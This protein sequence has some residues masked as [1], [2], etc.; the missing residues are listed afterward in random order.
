[1]KLLAFSDLHRDRD[2]ARRLADMSQDA[3][4]VIGAGDFAS[5]HFGLGRTIEALSS[6]VK[7]TL[8]VAGN[9]ESD[10]ALS[11][12]CASFS[13][14]K[15]LHGEATEIDG[16]SFFGLGAGIPPTPFPW[17]FDLDEERAGETLEECPEHAVLVVHSPPKGVVDRAFGRNLGS[18]AIRAAIERK[19]PRLA[20]CGHIHQ[21]WGQ[22]AKIG[23]TRVVNLGP[24]GKFFDL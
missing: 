22:E 20:L 8:L 3:D 10:A 9:N 19:H 13:A 2:A 7:P 24:E 14:A 17:S 16:V 1:M 5:M 18:K 6:I 15:V 11:R 21:G 23:E 4:V 12:A